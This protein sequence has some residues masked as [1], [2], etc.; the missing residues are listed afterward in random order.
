MDIKVRN[1]S[2]AKWL[3]ILGIVAGLFIIFNLALPLLAIS[4]FVKTYVIQ[5]L[6]WLL[7]AGLV[8]FLPRYT[9]AAGLRNRKYFIQIGLMLGAFHAIVLVIGGL[10]ARFGYSPYSFTFQSIITN[11]FF[12]SCMLIGMELS[13]AWLVNRMAGGRVFLTIT[14][15]A[16][17][18]TFLSIPFAQLTRIQ[19]DVG[20][21]PFINATL[22]P[23]F[24]EN[25]LATQIA[26]FGGPLAALAYRGILQAFWWFSPVLP[27]LPWVIKALIG[28]GVPVLGMVWVNSTYIEKVSRN[29]R[30]RNSDQGFPAGWIGVSVFAV[31]AVWF[32]IGLLPV[33]PSLI[34]SGSMSPA[35]NTGDVVI[36]AKIPASNIHEGDV[37]QFRVTRTLD[38]VHRVTGVTR[39]GGSLYFTTKGDAN[40]LAD[41]EQVL[42]DNVVGK[43]V[44]TVPKVGWLAIHIKNFVFQ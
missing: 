18:Y 33:Q 14:A 26:L 9:P 35:I 22:L 37:I 6:L 41:P 38:V 39:D 27:D 4:S 19:P 21:I 20:S 23:S 28:V 15:I 34:G 1:A 43:V 3:L 30:R 10:F 16:L 12:V 29:P 11:L 32:S 31:I 17:V 42:A 8:F 13:R 36:V 2:P 25:L 5:P 44:Y 24:A 40:A 7:L